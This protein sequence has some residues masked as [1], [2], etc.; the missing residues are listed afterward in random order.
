MDVIL[1]SEA[2]RLGL[3]HY[4]TGIACCRG[5]IER[6]NTK[7]G[8]CMGCDRVHH[9]KDYE[10]SPDDY[11]AKNAKSYFR[12]RESILAHR[13][14][15]RNADR[16]AWR[17]WCRDHYQANRAAILARRAERYKESP[18]KVRS[19]AVAYAKLHPE[20]RI[21]RMRNRRARKMGN[22]GRHSTA[23][24]AALIEK[25]KWK[26]ACGCGRSL[27]KKFHADHITPLVRGGSNAISN[28]QLLAPVCNLS[29][30]AKDPIVWARS[31]GR[32]L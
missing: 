12:H 29:K 6:R 3:R 10:A 26:C 16:D 15:K 13:A 11:V 21:T 8:K 1:R 14:D 32:L 5:H 7:N 27:R 20:V 30:H 17:A 4:F 22:G 2:K 28:I 19:D 25:Q 9:N 23:E 31:L 18:Y 24:I